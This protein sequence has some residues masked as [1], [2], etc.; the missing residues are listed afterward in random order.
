[1]NN[2]GDEL[3]KMTTKFVQLI[4]HRLPIYA[5]RTAI[6]HYQNNFLRGGFV[7]GGLHPWPEAKRLGSSSSGASSKYKTLLS[8]RKHLYSSFHYRAGVGG[9]TVFNDAKYAKIHQEGGVTHPRVTPRIRRYAWARY[10][11][12]KQAGKKRKGAEQLTGDAGMWKGLAL[13]SK[14]E[15]TVKIPARP[16]MGKSIELNETINKWVEKEVT[17]ILND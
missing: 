6:R 8:S 13:T 11:A 16:F 5:G 17:N 9:V 15:L 2:F 14:S 12:S 3:R 4:N 1:M 7:N 10:Y